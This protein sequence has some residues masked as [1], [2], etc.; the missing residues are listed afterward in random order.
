MFYMGHLKSFDLSIVQVYQGFLP[1][2]A[3]RE[4]LPTLNYR[5]SI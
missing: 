4:G 2:Q 3:S 5:Q 1:W